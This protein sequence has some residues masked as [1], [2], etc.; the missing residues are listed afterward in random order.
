VKPLIKWAGGKR[1]IAPELFS[2]FPTDWNRGTYIEPFIGGGAMFLF[3]APT[4][5]IIADL[6]SRLYGFYLQVKQ[7]P[8]TLYSGVIEIADQFNSLEEQ[9]K[10]DFYLSLRSQ[11]NESPVDSFQSASLLYVLNKLC[12][13]GLYRENSKGGFNVPFGQKKQLPYIDKEDL[14][15]VS[16]VLADTVILNS[17]F[18]TTIG[19]AKEGDFVYFDPPYIPIDATSS[20]TSYHSNG[21]AIEEQ[22]RLAAAMLRLKSLGVNAMC[23]NSDTPLTREI[24]E[25]L[26]LDSIQAPRMVS[27][28]ASGRGSVSEL[29]ITNYK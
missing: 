10:K 18:E 13:N 24:F 2:R 22:K 17:D 16:K 19:N 23:S 12:F 25:E 1:Q 5:A 14:G 27:A 6:N 15:S 26:H 20:F 7:N 28:K 8:E 9:D 29:V 3:A 4:R 11:Y 21:F